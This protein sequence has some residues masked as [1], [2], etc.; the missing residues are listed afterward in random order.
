M[1]YFGFSQ[2][3]LDFKDDSV[4]ANGLFSSVDS[5]RDIQIIIDSLFFGELVIGGCLK[6]ELKSKE[7]KTHLKTKRIEAVVS[8]S[9]SVLDGSQVLGE[10]GKTH[11]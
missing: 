8:E 3:G 4:L 5:Q 7:N 11:L 6:Q 9:I 2:S 1:L 10:F